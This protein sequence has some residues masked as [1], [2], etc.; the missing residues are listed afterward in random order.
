MSEGANVAVIDEI[1]RFRNALIVYLSKVRPVLEDSGD[2]VFRT[3]EWLRT[4][5]RIRWEN[6][7]RKYSRQLADAEQALFS[8]ELAKLRA[9]SSAEQ[10]AVH[11]AKRGF[12]HAEEKLRKTKRALAFFEKEIQPQVN[13]LEHL[14]TLFRTDLPRGVQLLGQLVEKLEA[15]AQVRPGGTGGA[16]LDNPTIPVS[17]TSSSASGTGEG[18]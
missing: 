3:R 4:E 17:E 7:V 9:P 18:G 6:E 14:R 16:T 15:Y 10:A 5:Q 13:Q 1:A 2:E 8:A 11:K 12:T